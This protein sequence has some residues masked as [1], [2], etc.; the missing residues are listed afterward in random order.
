[1]FSRTLRS[2]LILIGFCSIPISVKSQ[3][4]YSAILSPPTADNFPVIH[5]YL[6]VY[7]GEGKFIHD[8]KSDQISIIEDNL[9]IPVSDIRKIETG[10]QFVLAVNLGPTFAIRDSNG[11]SRN[12]R[13]EG[14]LSGWAANHDS[15]NDDLS[16]LTNDG[17][18]H[19][20]LTNA[21]QWLN[22]YN[23][24]ATNPRTAVPSL[25]VLVRAIEVASDPVPR[26]GMGRAV[27]L[28]TPPPNQ[29]GIDSLQSIISLAKQESVKI[30]IWMVSSP[31]YFTSQGAVLL[32]DMANQT[33][34]RFFAFS[35]D[36]DFPGVDDYLESLRF[37]YSLTYDSQI[38]TN[39]PHQVFTEIYVDD[40][41]IES[42]TQNIDITIS[43]PNPIFL[44]PPLEIVRANTAPLVDTLSE[45]LDYT[46]EEQDLAIVVEF[47][48]GYPR[49]I[50]RTSLYVDGKLADEN[51][52]EPFDDFTWN[53]KGFSSS[54]NHLLQ[55]E[56]EDILG[57]KSYSIEHHIKITVQQTP[58]SVISSLRENAPVIAGVTAAVAGGILVLVMI[59]GGHIKPKAFGSRRKKASRK[60][61]IGDLEDDSL[62]Q[63]DGKNT[64][65][66]NQKIPKW[67][68]KIAW[69]QWD[70]PAPRPIAFL[71]PFN[72]I[73]Q[74]LLKNP[75][76]L[77][78]GEITFGRDTNQAKIPMNDPALENLHS[79]LIITEDEIITIF[80][81]KTTAG[82]WVNYINIPDD[83]TVIDHGDI[84]HIA[85]IGL[86]LKIVDKSRIPKAIVIP[87]ESQST[88]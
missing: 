87:V 19:V 84:I 35:S 28:L 5:S 62:I 63:I 25:D 49:T 81:E 34:G 4:A 70:K 60:L 37:I 45:Q 79:R 46:P 33:G 41:I 44:A 15:V 42:S 47:P 12:D 23:I 48:D 50:R 31:A 64:A 66:Q 2:I 59:V 85:H 69:S 7:D 32:A 57:L 78:A 30:F 14:A 40:Q 67:L 36:E 10:V 65:P 3:S 11:I 55:V 27:L 72:D 68:N 26:V 51:L 74:N 71:E 52:T 73:A 13:L 38:R 22:S 9:E 6:E 43:P 82:T 80:D 39:E 24:Y 75:I 20:H 61:K 54:G 8:L 83:G 17:P 18:E 1:M 77:S 88:E 29:T 86:R 21:V 76:P 56:I 16:F 58:Q 53:L